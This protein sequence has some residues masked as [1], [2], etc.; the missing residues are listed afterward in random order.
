MAGCPRPG[1]PEDVS[2]GWPVAPIVM[3]YRV[4]VHAVPDWQIISTALVM[5]LVIW[6]LLRVAGHLYGGAFLRSG[7]RV[8][9]RDLWRSRTACSIRSRVWRRIQAHHR[10]G[11]RDH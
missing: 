10:H 1:R 9:L 5:A 3:T 8:P 4:A 11:G 6:A 2:P 7:G